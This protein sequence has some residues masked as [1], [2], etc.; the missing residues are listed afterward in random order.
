MKKP[1]SVATLVV[2]VTVLWLTA[3]APVGMAAQPPDLGAASVEV[4]VQTEG[5]TEALA[6]HIQSLGGVVRFR[7][8]NVPAVAATVPADRLAEVASFAGVTLVEKDRLVSLSPAPA[9]GKNYSH[10]MAYKVQ[11]LAGVQ[12]EAVDPLSF[13]PASLPAGYANFLYTGAYPTWPDTGAGAGTVVAVVDT[14]TV[15]NVCLAHAVIGAPGFPDGY[16]ATGDGIPA[17]SPQNHWH[18]THVGGVIASACALTFPDPSDPL[19]QSIAAYLPWGPDF[20]PVFG[21]APEA[22]L[23]PVKVFPTSGAGVPTSI[24]LDGVDH[25]LTLKKTGTL[26]VDVV[27]MSLSGPTVWDGRDTFDRFVQELVQAHILV[28]AAA[29]NDGPIPNSVGS[30]ATSFG[31]VS[32]AALDYAPSSRV[33]YEYL[34]LSYFGTPGQGLVMRR[35]GEVRVTN[36][37]S[38]GPL[39]DGR[40]GPDIAALGMWTFHAGPNNELRWAGGTSFASPTVAGAAA[41]LN[42]YWEAQGHETD[43]V[44]LENVLLMGAD[45]LVVGSTWQSSND[46]GYGAV[47]VP[48]ALERLQNGDWKLKALADPGALT[49]NVLGAAVPGKVQT[50]E[51]GLVTLDPSQAYN[52]VF[53]IGTTTSQVTIEV[54]DIQAPDN[55]EYAYWPNSLE[56]HLQSAERTAVPHPLGFYWYPF[57]YGSAFEVVVED[58]PWTLDGE[59]MAYKP[60]EPG[61]MKLSLIGDYSN[62][63]PVSFRLRITRENKAKLPTNRIANGLLQTGG[64]AVVPV[65]IP[66]GVSVATFDLRFG[67]DWA[68]FPTSDMDLLVFNPNFDLV[69]ID[70]ATLNAPERAVIQAPV[71][72]TWWVL[73][74]A[75][76]VWKPD[77]YDLF[78]TLE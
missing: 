57:A 33:F 58:G 41:L 34:G 53:D 1:V 25:V 2:L 49:R 29:S 17:T 61:L 35:S 44:V 28:V 4:I 71:A 10:P 51:S 69:S 47:D 40:L 42:A 11:D 76:E 75:Y 55:W 8:R 77:N 6:G 67:R 3:L 32:A 14:G 15:P 65:A 19:Y 7:Y 63:D 70:G 13:S 26:D 62:E 39:S 16:N 22:Q 54:F 60:M 27:N 9:T 20:V 23:Y 48:A 21:Q 78:L 12:V 52:A 68:K 30:P 72:G 66:D 24:I 50:W 43:A 37:S 74:D 46:Q 5:S 56:V 31:A 64:Y 45:P 59:Q 18:G 36:F 73:I 38:R